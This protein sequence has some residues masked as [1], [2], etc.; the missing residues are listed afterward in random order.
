MNGIV[1][2]KTQEDRFPSIIVL[3]YEV[4]LKFYL[5]MG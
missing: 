4:L 1:N 2:A 3:F 5:S